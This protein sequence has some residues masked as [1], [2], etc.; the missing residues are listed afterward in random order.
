[1]VQTGSPDGG[2][3][4]GPEGHLTVA[5]SRPNTN[6]NASSH[7][8][9]PPQNTHQA[10]EAQTNNQAK[11]QTAPIREGQSGPGSQGDTKAGS[12]SK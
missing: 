6:T 8:T 5:P 7:Q 2:A 11:S 4:P 3:T 9:N 12:G 1:M 10:R